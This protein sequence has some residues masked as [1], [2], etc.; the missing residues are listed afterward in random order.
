MAP[1]YPELF[2]GAKKTKKS[3]TIEEASNVAFANNKFSNPSVAFAMACLMIAETA[4]DYNLV[5]LN[6]MLLELKAIVSSYDSN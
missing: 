6:Y 3:A 5:F 1:N 2:E 4:R